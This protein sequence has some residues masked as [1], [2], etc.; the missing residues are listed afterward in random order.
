MSRIP[1]I[2]NTPADREAML[3]AIGV[4]TV[5]DLFDDVPARFRNAK[6]NLPAPLTEMELTGELRQQSNL[7]ANL[8]DHACFLGAGY[9]RHFIPAVVHHITGRSEFYTAY[10]P[11]EAE[12]SQGTLQAMFEYQSLVCELTGMEV[13]NAGLYDGS[14]AAAEAALMACRVTKRK[15]A[16]V[17]STVDPR[18]R[19][20]IA[21]Y[22]GGNDIRVMTAGPDADGLAA[23]TACLIVQYPDFYGCLDDPKEY[24]EK[25]HQAG[26]LL[27]VIVNPIA[28]GMLKPPG[29]CGADIVVADGQ[30]LGNPLNFGGPGLGL[31]ACRKEHVRQMPGRLVGKTVDVEGKTGYVLTLSTREQHIRRE[32]ATSNICSNE[33]LVALAA[34]VY[35]SAVGPAG[36]RRIAELCYHK[37]HYAAG[38]ISKLKGYS[39]AFDKPFF[40]EFVIKCPRPP[41]EIN[42]KLLEQK[43]IG[44]L[45][46]G[47]A[48]PG[49]MLLCATELNTRAGI[50]RLVEILG[51]V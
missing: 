32:K 41:A 42:R 20:V 45:D 12:V 13:S 9:Y 3:R 26:A 33:A 11:Y 24:A 5:D 23:D 22:A 44:G 17:A 25:A 2:P 28:L 47:P 14:S 43:I 7:N 46:L 16:A 19:K 51:R 36:L 21:T 15:T 49:C 29:A 10:T 31:F 1:Y 37:A 4:N 34:T 8:E 18:H 38:R 30:S 6:F 39:V 50:D 27:I 40:N 48:M 35:L